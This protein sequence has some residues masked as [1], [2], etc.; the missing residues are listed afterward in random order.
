MK[1]NR[2]LFLRLTALAIAAVILVL[3][4]IFL[5]T[6]DR[7]TSQ[8]ENR[9][10]QTFPGLTWSGL[11]SGDFMED[12]ES[13]VEDQFPFRTGWIKLKTTAARLMGSRESN[14]IFL[15]SG[16]YVIQDF[17]EPEAAD[18][19]DTLSALSAF[20]AAHT[21][22]N[23]YLLVAPTA[24][25]VLKD[26]LPLGAICGD[27]AGYLDRL[28]QDA[29]AAGLTVIDVRN[30]LTQAVQNGQQVFYRTDHHWTTDGAYAA[31]LALAD[32]AGLSGS[33]TAYS[34]LLIS[35]SFQ[36]TLTA[37]SGFRMSETDE[38][39][40]YVP[41]DSEVVYCVTYPEDGTTSGTFYFTENLEQRNQY[42]VFFNENHGE[43]DIQTSAGTGRT[44]LVLKDSYANCFVPFLAQDFDK[45]VMIDPRYYTDDLTSLMNREGFTDVLYLYNATSLAEDSYLQ[46]VLN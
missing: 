18:Y 25:T 1:K 31:Y 3:D 41:T 27:E 43:V 30:A 16:G 29:A 12:F 46:Q 17:T 19:Q 34:R 9:S 22:L 5:I 39:Y 21:G 10:L 14:G 7:K 38:L 44:L 11:T 13:Y 45:I 37:S 6:P 32:T 24:I 20:T 36:G 42:T 28:E 4:L 2:K 15:A 8:V 23:Q 35:D 33:A 40:V 26:K